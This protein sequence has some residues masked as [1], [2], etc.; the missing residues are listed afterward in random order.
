[1]KKKKTRS[2]S[3]QMGEWNREWWWRPTGR[4]WF[5]MCGMTIMG[6][7][8]TVVSF[9][10]LLGGNILAFL[11]TMLGG[12][13]LTVAGASFLIGCHW[14][15]TERNQFR[16][17]LVN[18]VGIMVWGPA[19]VL[20]DRP[21]RYAETLRGAVLLCI[22]ICAVSV[23]PCGISIAHLIWTRRRENMKEL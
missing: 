20:A 8:L 13:G 23:V 18:R 14:K 4:N 12:L 2:G 5:C 16:A 21:W 17:C 1:M 11:G 7:G 3:G 15:L 6:M 10:G 9:G 22:F 19:V